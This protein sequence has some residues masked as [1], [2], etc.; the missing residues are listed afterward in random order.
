MAAFLYEGVLL[1]GVVMG[2]GF[3]Y[4]VAVQQH[5]A[6]QQREGMQAALFLALSAY[7]IGF[8]IHGGQTLAM[9][10]W[11]LRVLRAD[12]LPLSLQQAA[13]RYVLSWLWFWPPLLVCWLAQWH[14][15]YEILGLML[16]WIGMYAGLSKLTPQRQFLH[17]HL[18]KTRLID[19]RA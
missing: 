17:D 16:V 8:W 7:F 15:K 1:F 11:Q 3:A 13:I 4:S 6:M 19:T 10:T 2:V 14:R 12:G 18:C 5:N 9:K